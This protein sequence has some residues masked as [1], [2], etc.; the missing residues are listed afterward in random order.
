MRAHL[1]RLPVWI[2]A[3]GLLA[4]LGSASAQGTGKKGAKNTGYEPVV[5]ELHQART[6]LQEANHDYDGYRAKA[7]HE[8][9]KAMHALHPN[10][11]HKLPKA[12]VPG[13]NEDQKVSDM[14]L[15]QASKQVQV[16]INQLTS[17]PANPAST[18]AVQNL[19][20][21]VAHLNTALKIR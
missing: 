3:A 8:I 18:A 21:A 12:A 15:A 4:G 7:V 1:L 6:L 10:H 20:A 19:Q 11:K 9:G 16:V 5:H 13:G 17:A 2:V 14:Q